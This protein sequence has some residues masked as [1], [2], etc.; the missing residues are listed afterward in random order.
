MIER[1]LTKEMADLWKEEKRFE[2]WFL[3]E[4]TVAEVQ[5]EMGIIP[6]ECAEEI[7]KASFS[8][9]EIKELEK[10]TG[11]DVI[12]FLKSIENHLRD[13]RAKSY[14]H[15]GLTSYDIVDT[16]WALQLRDGLDIVINSLKK[17]KEIVKNLA[18]KYKDLAMMGRTHGI[19]AE[20]ITFGLKLLSFYCEMDRNINRLERARE[21]IS[22]GKIS[23]AVGTYSTLSP[24]VEKEVLR[25][26]NLKVEP[27]STQIVPRDRYAYLVSVCAIVASSFERIA[28][29]IRNLQRSEIDEVNEPFLERQKGS[30]AMPHKRNPILCERIVSLARYIRSLI[31]P[32]LENISLWHERDLTNSANERIVFPNVLILLHY[33]TERMIFI[34]NNL[35]VNE[36]KMKE[37]LWKAKDLYFSSILL[38]LLM[39]KG[40]KRSVAYDLVQKLSFLAMEKDKSFLEVIKE[41]EEIKRYLNEEELKEFLD[42]KYLLRNVE[43][44]FRRVIKEER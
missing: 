3:V 11:H 8:L 17:L 40:L 34:F 39:K 10:E 23:G 16:A 35:K 27:V 12:A 33:I 22:Y 14:L 41:D 18:L 9:S 29:E 24:E 4:K 44:I 19:F 42:V 15:Y 38:I 36:E 32:A 13:E 1:Y 26:L 6:K 20:P 43:E 2:Y 28:T 21:E 7:K 5:G 30:S 37:N 31:F 25:R